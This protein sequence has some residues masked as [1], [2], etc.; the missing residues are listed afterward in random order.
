M[1]QNV[2]GSM[3]IDHLG[4]IGI[5]GRIILKLNLGTDL[6]LDQVLAICNYD[7]V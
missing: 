5:A 7:E 2:V 3:R 4:D 6:G 1:R